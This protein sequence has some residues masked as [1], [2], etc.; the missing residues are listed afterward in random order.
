MVFS[1]THPNQSRW[2]NSDNVH[3]VW[4]G[5]PNAVYKYE[6]DSFPDTIPSNTN[7]TQDTSI[8]I[9]APGSGIFYFHL[10]LASGGPVAHYAVQIDRTP[11]SII[12][13]YSSSQNIVSGDVVRFSFEAEDIGSGV[14]QNYYADLGN[15]LFLPIGKDFSISFLKA[16]E[17]EV[18]LRVYDGAYN[19]S[20]KSQ[21]IYVKPK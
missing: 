16:G 4:I 9:P 21:I 17:Q 3:F 14:Q 13:V 10:Q 1:P 11:P 7:T 2:Y 8:T 19:Y 5:K 20:E 6:F 12:G 15:H 18:T